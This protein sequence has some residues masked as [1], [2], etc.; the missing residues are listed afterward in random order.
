MLALSSVDGSIALALVLVL[1]VWSARR[2]SFSRDELSTLHI[3]GLPLNL[4]VS[5]TPF[6]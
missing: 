1:R 6:L 2:P 3:C 5:F 4:T